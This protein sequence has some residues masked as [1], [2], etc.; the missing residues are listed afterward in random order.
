MHV[1]QIS[2][3]Y[4]PRVNGVS[5]SIETFR[6]GLIPHD[7]ACTLIAP[8]YGNEPAQ[9]GVVRVPGRAVPFDPE[10]R[11]AR[12]GA[13]VRAARDCAAGGFDLVHVQTPFAAHF[14]GRRLARHWQ[15]PLVISYHTL[16]EEYLHHYVP[17][18]PR[19]LTAALARRMS[20]WQCGHADR[21]IAPSSAMRE[22]LRDYGVDTPIEVLPTGIPLGAFRGADG[23]R[24]RQAHGI[25]PERPVALTVSRL[26]HE[27][28]IDFLVAAVDQARQACPALLLLVAGE[29]PAEAA[30]RKQ[31]AARG[32]HD[33]VRF[34]GYLE[35]AQALPDCYAAADLFVF[36]SR[37]ET[38]GLVLLE[39]MASGTG[40]LALS[41]MGTAS[42][43]ETGCGC[44]TAR[45][46]V[47]D[48]AARLAGCLSDRAQSHRLG[49]AARDGAAAW[50]DD[51]MAGRLAAL[52]RGLLNESSIPSQRSS[53][54]KARTRGRP[55]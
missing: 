8:A 20:R 16:F 13:M 39:A 43:L 46:D 53:H 6:R 17:A 25:A 30:L 12:V 35:R 3:V 31:V 48:F 19:A 52:Y 24:F 36:A 44:L 42:I 21:V 38:Q 37:T 27:K 55:A 11:I 18:A 32:L 2:D 1:L 4:F 45:D 54:W 50:S 23:G 41:C 51:A 29:G 15:V 10:D 7:V 33:H 49:L 40:V 14:A 9:P 26:A 47:A 28:N 5:T 22:R 34:L